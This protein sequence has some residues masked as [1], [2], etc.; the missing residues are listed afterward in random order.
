M[1]LRSAF[2]RLRPSHR[3]GLRA[4][5]TLA[6][7]LGALLLSALLAGTT[8]ALTRENLLNQR[9]SAATDRALTNAVIVKNN[10]DPNQDITSLLEGLARPEG[11]NPLVVYRGT[12]FALTDIEFGLDNLPE[13][14]VDQVASGQPSRMLYYDGGRPFLAVGVPIE[15]EDALYF[16]GASLVDLEDTLEGL[17]ISLL[18]AAVLTTLAGALLGF[19][20]SKRVLTPL[21]DVGRAAEAIAGGR[22]DTRLEAMDDPDLGAITASFNE[23]AQ[24]LEERIQRDARFASEV[25]HE[26][27][28]PLMTLSASLEVLQNSR[29]Q[30]SERAQTALD[31]LESDIERFQQLV[32]DLLEISRFDAGA[33]QL[34]LQ[35]TRLA[36]LV[37][38]AVTSIVGERVAAVV[39]P[40]AA[41]VEVNVDRRRIGQVL[42][43][44]LDNAERYA[45][46]A[47]AVVVSAAPGVARIAVEDEGPGVPVD[48]RTVI[49]DRFSRGSAGGKRG[50][51]LGTGLGLSL[52]AEHINLHGG[53]VWVEDRLDGRPGARFVVELPVAL[54]R[55]PTSDEEHVELVAPDEPAE[56]GLTME[57]RL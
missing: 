4:R 7:G 36:D 44:L 39:E 9:N 28:S 18:G 6:F 50:D 19:Y 11:A 46:G 13:E 24:A 42:A 30:L 40:E 8:Y 20:A 21:T 41:N 51:D 33:V 55:E 5:I 12:P 54:P 57:H 1:P 45:N 34:D 49:F 15:S 14:F 17:G 27:R 25:S 16:E 2:H 31:L 43:N 22:L 38:Q 52:V 56:H 47:T 48:E 53:R 26:L 23:M 3:F 32:E 37:Q 29:Q 10:L 35:Q